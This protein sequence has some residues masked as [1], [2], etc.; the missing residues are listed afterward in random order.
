MWP[1]D[2]LFNVRSLDFFLFWESVLEW[3]RSGAIV[4]LLCHKQ[5]V[6]VTRALDFSLFPMFLSISPT[7]AHVGYDCSACGT[8][9]L[10]YVHVGPF[11]DS[12]N[13]IDTDQNVMSYP[14]SARYIMKFCYMNRERWQKK[15]WN[16]SDR[17][18]VWGF[19]FLPR[20]IARF[21]LRQFWRCIG[22][23]IITRLTTLDHKPWIFNKWII[24]PLLYA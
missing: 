18:E 23:G 4:P 16:H 1:L 14:F 5:Q 11:S 12:Q 20:Y 2:L 22:C 6:M 7:L 3:N 17:H 21:C 10:V 13:V 24:I 8:A 19:N 15:N 9:L